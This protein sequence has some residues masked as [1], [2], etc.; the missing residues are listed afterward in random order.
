MSTH[1]V[2]AEDYQFFDF[3]AT[4]RWPNEPAY[5]IKL[6]REL[7]AHG[8]IQIE[9]LLENSLCVVSRGRY[10]R[11]AKDHADCSD[12]SD[13]KKAVSQFRNNDIARDLWTNSFAITNLKNKTGLIRALCLSKET[14]R[15]H[16]F[17]IPYNAYKGMSRIDISLDNSVGYCKPKGIPKGKWCA[18]E[19]KSFEKLATVRHQDQARINHWGP[20]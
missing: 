4:Y 11:I 12:G 19:V 8:E 2:T 15:F 13:A 17:A 16:F 6:Y 18:F 14:A 10:S 5:K 7:V 3:L 9:T 20:R 1:L